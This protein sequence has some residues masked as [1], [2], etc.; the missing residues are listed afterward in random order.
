MSSLPGLE[1]CPA[2]RKARPDRVPRQILQTS[3]PNSTRVQ[4][5]A[6]EKFI[7]AFA[8]PSRIW[9]NDLWLSDRR[10]GPGSS[11]AEMKHSRICPNHL[12]PLPVTPA[13]ACRIEIVVIISGKNFACCYAKNPKRGMKMPTARDGIEKCKNFMG[14]KCS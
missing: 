14:G 10:L 4:F 13:S 12:T 2:A 6:K 8:P 1:G 3:A 7:F 9:E 11:L 5:P